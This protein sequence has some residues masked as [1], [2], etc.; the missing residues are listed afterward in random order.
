MQEF[1]RRV[2]AWVRHHASLLLLEF[3]VLLIWAIPYALHFFL[4]PT[5][6]YPRFV[7]PGVG[8]DFSVY[9][10]Y[11]AQVSRGVY[12]FFDR[13][14]SE[15]Q[16]I[17][18]VNVFWLLGGLLGRAFR[19]S[20]PATFILLQ[21]L[22]LPLIP[23][24]LYYAT[25]F[26][27]ADRTRR[28]AATYFLQFFSGI[29]FLL[30]PFTAPLYPMD[31]F[32]PHFTVFGHI[33]A[34]PHTMLGFCF[35]I[36]IPLLFFRYTETKAARFLWGSAL[37]GA[38]FFQFQPYTFPAIFFF[39]V[40]WMF[41]SRR[42]F[43]RDDFFPLLLAFG[44]ML[45]PVFYH[46]LTLFFDPFTALRYANNVTKVPPFLQS[47][48]PYLV[49]LFFAFLGM[50]VP[51]AN[52]R[53]RS[54]L[55]LWFASFAIMAAFPFA[56]NIRFLEGLLFPLGIF[57][58]LG[59][60][61]KGEGWRRELALLPLLLCCFLLFG[62]GVISFIHVSGSMMRLYYP[63][64]FG[65]LVSVLSRERSA[66]FISS[67]PDLAGSLVGLTPHTAYLGHWS[68]TLFLREKLR[69]WEQLRDEQDPKVVLT[70]LIERNITFA[71]LCKPH[72]MNASSL[73]FMQEFGACRLYRVP[74]VPQ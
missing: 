22:C 54:F 12:W 63:R 59:F 8:G 50:R 3:L 65:A 30:L 35:L 48:A 43:T 46:F 61:Q 25:G 51:F 5:H 34:S 15:P 14:T 53:V 27:F 21:F 16:A 28:I 38:V 31:L 18:I 32:A 41:F 47:V 29:G 11:L 60:W 4:A 24:T 33:F 13:F 1:F 2:R 68:D 70:Y 57:A 7:L 55:F 69:S 9:E 49:L 23:I 67:D 58:F 40:L 71:V 19:L 17:G 37:L 20:P 6:G 64:E 52:P 74:S 42:R 62:G 10:S 39:F 36:L 72:I 45:L 73:L 66:V 44:C 26:I 56:N